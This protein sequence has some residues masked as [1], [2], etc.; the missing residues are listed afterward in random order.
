M[1]GSSLDYRSAGSTV[2]YCSMMHNLMTLVSVIYMHSLCTRV[3]TPNDCKLRNFHS[4]TRLWLAYN[5]SVRRFGDDSFGSI[6]RGSD[7]PFLVHR[8]KL[9][10]VTVHRKSTWT[11]LRSNQGLHGPQMNAYIRTFI[12]K[13]PFY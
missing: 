12:C 1:R 10:N 3:P 9:C 13:P 2:V 11:R 5:L 6:E 4:F 8:E 7:R